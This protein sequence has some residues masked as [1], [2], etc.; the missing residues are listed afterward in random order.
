M[1]KSDREAIEFAKMQ[2]SAY[3]CAGMLLVLFFIA[4]GILHLFGIT[5]AQ[6]LAWLIEKGVLL[7]K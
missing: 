2:Q 3:G 5:D 4:Y 7:P 1:D 6:I